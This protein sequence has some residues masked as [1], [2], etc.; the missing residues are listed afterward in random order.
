MSL[1]TSVLLA[2]LTNF[3]ALT[4]GVCT[5]VR[6]PDKQAKSPAEYEL[7]GPYQIGNELSQTEKAEILNR[8]RGFLWEH[9]DG[10]VPG[11]LETTF[12]TTEGKP[13]H[14]LFLVAADSSGEWGIRSKISMWRG[15]YVRTKRKPTQSV[16]EEK[17]CYVGRIDPLSDKVIPREERRT[18]ESYR[19]VLKVCPDHDI[20]F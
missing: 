7:A 5:Q 6:L 18:A 13:T 8:I 3:L 15:D 17:Y 14:Y 12:Y 20:T 4:H 16:V 2:A 9:F 19:L 10:K 1:R 11:R